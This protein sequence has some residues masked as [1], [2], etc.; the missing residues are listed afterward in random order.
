MT[1]LRGESATGFKAVQD[2][3]RRLPVRMRVQAV[4]IVKEVT[5]GEGEKFRQVNLMTLAV[6]RHK[7][8]NANVHLVVGGVFAKRVS[9]RVIIASTS[10]LTSKSPVFSTKFLPMFIVYLLCSLERRIL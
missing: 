2:G 8:R 10:L 4:N 6:I 5:G 7:E 1:S 3:V 9:R